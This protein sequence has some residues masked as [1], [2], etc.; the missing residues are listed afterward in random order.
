MCFNNS[1]AISLFLSISFLLNTTILNQMNFEFFEL[2]LLP[3]LLFLAYYFWQKKK[4]FLHIL[5]LSL[6]LFV[7][8]E[9]FAIVFMFGIYSFLKKREWK[10]GLSPIFLGLIWGFFSYKVIIPFFSPTGSYPFYYIVVEGFKKFN[11]GSLI[12]REN[13]LYLYWLLGP[14]FIILPFFS[15]EWI[16]GLPILFGALY[17][18]HYGAKDV[19]YWYHVIIV[20]ILFISLSVAIKFI[21]NRFL[22]RLNPEK[23]KLIF[24]SSVLMLTVAFSGIYQVDKIVNFKRLT[25]SPRPILEEVIKLVPPDASILAPRYTTPYFANRLHV[26]FAIEQIQKKCSDFVL[27]DT[28]TNDNFTISNINKPFT[29]KVNNECLYKKIYDQKGV[30]LYKLSSSKK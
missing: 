17:T 3:F 7:R 29:E 18:P 11:M 21:G 15:W 22:K 10:W 12:S 4:F 2:H 13:I 28:N 30:K 14:L 16:I 6:S 19:G 27:I 24:A 20:S 25:T 26:Y 9:I 1:K 8:E 23:T 5:F